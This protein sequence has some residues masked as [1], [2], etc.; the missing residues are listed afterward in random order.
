MNSIK[1]LMP[2]VPAEREDFDRHKYLFN[3]ENGIIDLKTGKLQQHDREL[4]LTKITNVEFD[5]S[6]KYPTWAVF[7][8]QIFKGDKDLIDYMQ[9]L[10]GYSF[11]GDISEG[12]QCIS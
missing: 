7:L 11:T 9:R 2:L 5:E 12:N 6:A 10:V 3:V 1:D 4:G 8:E